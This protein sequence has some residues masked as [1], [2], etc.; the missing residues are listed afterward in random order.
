MSAWRPANLDSFPKSASTSFLPDEQRRPNSA[1]RSDASKVSRAN[2]VANSMA[3]R[4]SQASRASRASRAL[5]G[6]PG[7]QQRAIDRNAPRTPSVRSGV[8]SR[9]ASGRTF[10]NLQQGNPEYFP[11]VG[12]FSITALPGYTGYIPA[13]APEN[14]VGAT[15][16]RANEL[17]C[18]AAESRS[19]LPLIG[20]R[21]VNPWGM[22]DRVG[23][24]IPGYTG[25]IPGKQ[26]D[27]VFAH[28][29]ARE[30]ELA[31]LIKH[32]Q[33]A[34]K[35]QRIESYRQGRRPPTGHLDYAGYHDYGAG[36]GLEST[37]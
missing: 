14:V 6:P 20:G 8:S 4:A 15:Y 12:H 16:Q 34:D 35:H 9:T 19:N 21:R 11:D 23:A 32:R 31:Q 33:A 29:Y 37:G 17:A 10:H 18:V 30:N 3:S 7:T 25:F 13:K 2:S 24:L 27:N 22:G 5:S 1:A 36:S 26:A 28:T